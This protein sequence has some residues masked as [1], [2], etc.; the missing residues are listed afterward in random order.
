NTPGSHLCS[1]RSYQANKEHFN[2][3]KLLTSNLIP[4]FT[5]GLLALTSSLFDQP[6]YEGKTIRF[7]VRCIRA[8]APRFVAET[9]ACILAAIIVRASHP[10]A[11]GQETS[12]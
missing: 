12:A 5:V 3:K 10:S 4:Y 7:I 2:A 8:T 9:L 11:C 1:C 6:F